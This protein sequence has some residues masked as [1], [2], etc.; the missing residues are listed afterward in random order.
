MFQV[1]FKVLKD[2]PLYDII[3]DLPEF[4]STFNEIV[5]KFE[6]NRERIKANL[7]KIGLLPIKM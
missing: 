2:D 1:H 4:Q 3:R 6:T 5:A 7:T